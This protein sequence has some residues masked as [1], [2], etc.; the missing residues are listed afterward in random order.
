MKADGK[1]VYDLKAASENL[2][3]L[4]NMLKKDKERVIYEFELAINSKRIIDST[5]FQLTGEEFYRNKCKEGEGY[6]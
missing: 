3:L 5:I 6:D 1:M 2:N 4:Q